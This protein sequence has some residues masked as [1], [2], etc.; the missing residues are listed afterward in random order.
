MATQLNRVFSRKRVWRP[1]ECGHHLINQS[2]LLVESLPK[3]EA[4]GSTQR[5]LLL[6]IAGM[7]DTLGERN[8]LRA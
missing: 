1:E 7:K 8:R 5:E 4:V 2:S 3:S 6:R